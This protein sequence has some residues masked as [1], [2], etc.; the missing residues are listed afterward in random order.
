MGEF[1]RI[2][3]FALFVSGDVVG[4]CFWSFEH[5]ADE[6]STYFILKEHERM[7]TLKKT[8]SVVLAV[9]MILC[10][11][12]AMSFTV[13]AAET[14]NK[15]TVDSNLCEPVVYDYNSNTKQITVTYYL[16]AEHKLLN[17]QAKLFYD[18]DVL[19]LAAGTTNKTCLPVLG[20]GNEIINFNKTGKVSFCSTSLNLYDFINKGVFFTATFDVIGSGDT[21]VNL[22]V[23]VI[24]G[25]TANSYDELKGASDIEYVYYNR[26][27][28]S[29]YEMTAEAK[30]I[31]EVQ[32]ET[33]VSV[34][35]DV[36]L[37]LPKSSGTVYAARIDLA[38]GEYKF[39]INVD[40]K[41]YG[42]GVT[43]ADK[44][45]AIFKT[46]W[47]A[48][49]TLKATGGTYAF[50]FDTATGKCNVTKKG[51]GAF[52]IGDTQVV[53]K[54]TTDAVYTGTAKLE[55][56]DYKI[57]VSA[58][59]KQYGKGVAFTDKISTI[60]KTD[61]KA[62]LTMTATGGTYAF[63]F[64]EAT[65]MLTVVKKAEGVSVIGDIKLNLEKSTGTKYTATTELAAG[66]Y[67]IKVSDGDNEYGKGIAFTD[68]LNAVLKTT[69][70]ASAT[71]TATGGEYTFTFDTATG[72]LTV[73]KNGA[74]EEPTAAII[75]DVNVQLKKAADGTYTGTADL[76]AGAYKIKVKGVNGKE[77]GKG[78]AFTDKVNTIVKTDW[79]ASLTM[80]A[81]GG[82]YTFT[83]NPVT[84]NI[85][86]S[87]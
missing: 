87:K 21:T 51:D 63:T 15:I 44:V 55:A 47:K 58:N 68:K 26:L 22:N 48:S 8:F 57:K 59:N 12:T 85:V 33:N 17:A 39:K 46:E 30:L 36:S 66:T 37:T 82:T 1:V 62:S 3:Y 74:V 75:G 52:I 72:T 32:P 42:K 29:G 70:K 54:K 80:T 31:Q 40:G 64:D 41:Q 10:T 69:W 28:A 61:W 83:F 79:K 73:G 49:A 16:K 23:E 56:G 35:G 45:S 50:A 24:T 53:L 5:T 81:T 77:Y 38:P 6:W 7:K 34:I 67:K 60:V 4:L 14:T 76:A 71:M 84:G 86:V 19:K 27:A 11:F 65:G 13:S 9:M 78:L 25:T 2:Y 20:N 43:F 18:S